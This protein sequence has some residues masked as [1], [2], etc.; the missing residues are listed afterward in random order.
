MADDPGAQ[1][2]HDGVSATTV[3]AVAKTVVTA[4]RL[5]ASMVARREAA[6]RALTATGDPDDALAARAFNDFLL[7]A[8]E[9][10]RSGAALVVA[11]GPDG[12]PV[13]GRMAVFDGDRTPCSCRGTPRSAR[14]SW[15]RRT[16]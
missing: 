14:P 3:A 4:R 8:D 12:Q 10:R 5:L 7:Q 9:V 1:A 2:P 15:W 11:T 16:A 13:V 6:V